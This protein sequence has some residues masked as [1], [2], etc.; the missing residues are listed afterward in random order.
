MGERNYL[1]GLL[2]GAVRRCPIVSKRKKC[3]DM[4]TLFASS[5]VLMSL[6][7]S[8]VW[9]LTLDDLVE[10]DGLNY[11]KFTDFPFTGEVA[12]GPEKG[13]FKN[14]KKEGLWIGYHSNGQLKYKGA[15]WEGSRHGAWIGYFDNG[16][17]SFKG[18]MKRDR[19][20][21]LWEWYYEDGQLKSRGEFINGKRDGRWVWFHSNGNNWASGRYS[22]DKKQDIWK[23]FSYDGTPSEELSGFY[24]DNRKYREID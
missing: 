22:D 7:S 14:G 17:L 12:E 18:T 3:V 2:K 23:F 6:I 19:Q 20:D 24:S 21:G 8:Q 10:R 4:K 9:S 16:N 11:E 5:L 15:W 13:L 1:V